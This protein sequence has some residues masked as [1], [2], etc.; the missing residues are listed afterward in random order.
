MRGRGEGRSD[1]THRNATAG[2]ATQRRV[3]AQR[4]G[5]ASRWAARGQ[6]SG[7]TVDVEGWVSLKWRQAEGAAA[8]TAAADNYSA[9]RNAASTALKRRAERG[10]ARD[11]GGERVRYS[12]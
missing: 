4:R 8:H 11:V 6:K 9:H 2:N 3:V 7:A 10:G 1:A 5:C 12:N